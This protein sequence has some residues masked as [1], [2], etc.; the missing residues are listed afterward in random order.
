MEP[1]VKVEPA[2]ADAWRAAGRLKTVDRCIV[3]LAV[4]HSRSARTIVR[5]RARQTAHLLG[6]RTKNSA[7]AKRIK[8]IQPIAAT[9][10][11]GVWESIWYPLYQDPKVRSSIWSGNQIK[12]SNG[13]ETNV[14][15][16]KPEGIHHA[17]TYAAARTRREMAREGLSVIVRLTVML[18]GRTTTSDR[19]RGRVSAP[20]KVRT[21]CVHHFA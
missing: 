18:R 4:Y 10:T 21:C 14:T 9:A 11:P 20:A 19:R 6:A 5:R 16:Q 12:P 2:S 1:N 8:K 7:K 15:I 3:R 17:R 13:T